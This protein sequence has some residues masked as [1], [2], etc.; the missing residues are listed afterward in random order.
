MKE[1]F[2]EIGDRVCSSCERPLPKKYSDTKCPV[3]K[4]NELFQEVREY[5]RANVV[6]EYMVAEKFDIPLSLVRKWIKEGRIEYSKTKQIITSV[7]CQKC[8]SP[9]SFGAICSDCLQQMNAR[10]GVYI[11]KPSDF[12]KMRFLNRDTDNTTS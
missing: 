5:I 8:G 6:N 7:Y 11:Q 1:E 4:E 2:K 9:I 3:C 10:T 12:E